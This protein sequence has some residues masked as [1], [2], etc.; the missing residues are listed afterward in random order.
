MFALV[1]DPNGPSTPIKES[2][3]SAFPAACMCILCI[4]LYTLR[5]WRRFFLFSISS[6]ARAVRFSLVGSVLQRA[7][8][9]F[10][11]FDAMPKLHHHSKASIS[12]CNY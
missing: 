9:V 4:Y 2:C 3:S 11:V 12:Q 10:F 8:K 5:R 1:R 7:A 6:R